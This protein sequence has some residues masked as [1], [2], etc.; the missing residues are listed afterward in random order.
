MRA[1][2]ITIYL[3]AGRRDSFKGQFLL[4]H[5]CPQVAFVEAFPCVLRLEDG[6]EN[7]HALTFPCD[8]VPQVVDSSFDDAGV[9]FDDA[10]YVDFSSS[11]PAPPCR[12]GPW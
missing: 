4:H 10:H 8:A 6:E 7:D 1:L 9:S 11:D 5:Y 3:N 2:D 12:R